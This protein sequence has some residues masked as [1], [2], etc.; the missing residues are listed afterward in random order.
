MIF[1]ETFTPNVEMGQAI[2]VPSDGITWSRAALGRDA[3]GFTFK[4][5]E[6]GIRQGSAWSFT[7]HY[8]QITN[9]PTTGHIIELL[10]AKNSL[11]NDRAA[12]QCASL[13]TSTAR[14]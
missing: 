10:V 1:A 7:A 2:G 14:S 8:F 13:R 12:K 11:H 6:D 4:V 9:D 5:I 3:A